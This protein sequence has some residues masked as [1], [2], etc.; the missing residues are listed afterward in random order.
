MSFLLIGLLSMKYEYE[1]ELKNWER[2]NGT[3]Y[4]CHSALTINILPQLGKT[5]WYIIFRSFCFCSLIIW[6]QHDGIKTVIHSVNSQ[7]NGTK[8]MYHSV[9]ELTEW[10]PFC[11]SLH[12][13]VGGSLPWP[14]GRLCNGSPAINLLRHARPCADC[15]P[16]VLPVIF[17][18]SLRVLVCCRRKKSA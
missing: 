7:Q 9:F 17:E 14:W 11:L 3:W 16:P 6:K 8:I 12:N 4:W 1:T 2:K 15:G 18:Q 10:H 13:C 5:E